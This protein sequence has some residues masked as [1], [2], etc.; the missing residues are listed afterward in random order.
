[1]LCTPHGQVE[2]PA[3]IPLASK[4]SVKSLVPDDLEEIGVQVVLGN[5]YH[6]YLR[7]GADLIAE[8][9]GL[10]AFMGW[11]RPIITD[12]GG[13]QV[14][15]LGHG[16]VADEIKGRQARGPKGEPMILRI[17]E[18]GVLFRSYID[19]SIHEFSPEKSIEI[20]HKLGSDIILV[21][22]ECTPYHTTYDYTKRSMERTHRWAERCLNYHRESGVTGRALFGIIQGGVHPDLRKESA[23]Y[24]GS[25]PFEGV[26]IGGSLGKDKPEMYRVV[27]MTLAHLP[28]DKPRHLLGIGE[29]DDLFEGVERGIDLFDCAV[30]TR[31]ARHGTALVRRRGEGGRFRLDLTNARYQRDQG[32]LDP[33]CGCYACRNFTRAYLHYLLRA[34]EMT[35]IRLATYHNVALLNAFMRD[36]RASIEDGGFPALKKRFTEQ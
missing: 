12:S 36:I 27:E 19:G 8:M 16:T 26:A 5:T 23:E 35:G 33:D 14:F 13:F 17:G 24:I 34:N 30:P 20:Q 4:G 22:D 31:L 15:S 28:E 25:L 21:F 3:F 7:P 2:T 29:P 9:G 11:S 32:P 10:H 1:M 6:L 18:S